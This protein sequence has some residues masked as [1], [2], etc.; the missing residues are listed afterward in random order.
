M[1][2]LRSPARRRVLASL[3]RGGAAVLAGALAP[4]SRARAA[5]PSTAGGPA[6]PDDP[7]SAYLE[8]DDQAAISIDLPQ[9]RYAGRWEPRVGAM[10][11][12]ARELRLRTRLEP[13]AEPTSVE[14]ESAAL[15]A[16]PFLYVAGEGGLPPLS[17]GAEGALRRFLDFGGFIVFDAADGGTDDRFADDVAELLGRIAPGSP[18]AP[19]A[20][21]HVLYRTFYLIDAPYGR[22][23]T[24]SDLVG[25]QD[26]GRLRAVLVRNDLG[27][28]LAETSDGLPAHPCMPGGADQ[29]QWAI[30]FAVNLLL[31]ATCTDYKADRAHVETLLRSRRWK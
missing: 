24:F 28:A 22:T 29:R 1:A 2:D 4:R 7:W 8:P 23:A 31:Y 21:D 16:T 25:V 18:L 26:E 14:P 13:I 11:V 20:S 17:R 3:A 5:A 6:P 12:L 27:G 19:V 15:F 10:R 9:L 30:R